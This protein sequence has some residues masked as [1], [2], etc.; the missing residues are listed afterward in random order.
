M[1]FKRSL[2]LCVA[3]SPL[4]CG[5]IHVLAVTTSAAFVNGI[6]GRGSLATIFCTGLQ[7]ITGIQIASETPLPKVLAG[8]RIT[9]GT[10]DVP[11][12][13]V[14]D[15]GA[16]QIV[17]FQVPWENNAGPFVISQGPT[18]RSCLG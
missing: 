15:L 18:A 7:G 6:P 2:I 3:F 4:L 17:S 8:I 10:Q 11:L 5:E 12:L 16:Y 9:Q 14:A 1:N 13:A